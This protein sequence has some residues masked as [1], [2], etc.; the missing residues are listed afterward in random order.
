MKKLGKWTGVLIVAFLLI[1]VSYVAYKQNIIGSVQPLAIIDTGQIAYVGDTFVHVFTLTN[2]DT[3]TLPE[4]DT[5]DGVITR[6]YAGVRVT[7]NAG[8]IAN[9]TITEI[10]TPV[11]ASGTLP[12]TAALYVTTSTPSCAP[13]AQ[14]GA[15][16]ILF[17][18]V[19]TWD[20]GT[21]TWNTGSPTS[22]DDAS[23]TS[24]LAVK[25]SVQTPTA[26]VAP[27]GATL[28]TWFSNL[29]ASLWAAIKSLLGW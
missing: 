3:V 11:T 6:L 2:K 21:N 18:V 9:E 12:A 10:I 7:N 17:K 29:F 24:A 1:A 4:L 23:K 20:R 8:G 22:I 16:A 26:P 28:T 5:A 27:S 19:Q 13:P 15:S 25:F 14:C